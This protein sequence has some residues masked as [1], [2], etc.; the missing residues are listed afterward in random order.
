[1][2]HGNMLHHDSKVH[3]IFNSSKLV[4]VQISPVNVHCNC[5]MFLKLDCKFNLSLCYSS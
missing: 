5:S 2:N 3:S 4:N 1:M